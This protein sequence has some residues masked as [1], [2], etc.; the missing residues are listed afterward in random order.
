MIGTSIGSNIL[1]NMLG[2]QG[3][4][5]FITAAVCVHSA[6]K[7]WEMQKPLKESLNGL[8]DR[9]MGKNLNKLLL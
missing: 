6:I 2:E 7:Y 3:D 4:E 1:A 8:Y 9:V 5:S